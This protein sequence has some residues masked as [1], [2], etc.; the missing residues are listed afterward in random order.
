MTRRFTKRT[1]GGNARI[2]RDNYSN[3]KTSWW[4]IRKEVVQRDGGKCQAMA[5]WSKCGKPAVEVH[6]ITPLS[7]GGLTTKANLISLCKDCHDARH[8]HLKRTR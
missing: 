8:N 6:H 4:D 7:R 5:G 2:V 1:F 3:S